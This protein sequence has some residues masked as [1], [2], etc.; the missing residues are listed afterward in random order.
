MK[1]PVTRYTARFLIA[2]FA[3]LA[4]CAQT[5]P[6]APPPGAIPPQ[7]APVLVEPPRP[8]LK[9][10]PVPPPPPPEPQQTELYRLLA[11]SEG[12]R[13][14]AAA[15]AA[16]ELEQARQSFARSKTDYNRLFYALLLLL[17]STGGPDEARAG[18]LLEPIAKDKG[19]ANGMRTFAAFVYY[20]LAE[21]RKL[22]ERMREEQKRADSLQEKLDALK[23][24]EKSLI[25][26][27]QAS[28]N[29]R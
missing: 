29:K 16:K 17:P 11:Q 25:D 3:V 7:P 1:T 28:P 8:E 9:P 6:A 12:V 27:E 18:A 22:E 21:N 2:S 10:E 19:G 26:R 14:M 5:K 20:Q 23:E 15:D 4:A 13:K 24:V